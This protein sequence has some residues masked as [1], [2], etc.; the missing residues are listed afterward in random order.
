MSDHTKGA[1]YM[2]SGSQHGDCDYS[3]YDEIGE[4]IAHVSC[5]PGAEA[6]AN[7]RLLRASPLLLEAL[8]RLVK[9]DMPLTGDPSHERLVEFWEWE[10]TQ[11][12]EEADDQLFVLTALQAARGVQ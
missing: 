10:K 11:G 8:E 3:I 7:A 4:D 6:S 12:R 1:W 9:L 5:R 2:Q